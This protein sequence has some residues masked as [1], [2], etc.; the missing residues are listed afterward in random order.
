MAEIGS[1]GRG[2]TCRFI[3]S[4]LQAAA[5]ARS[6]GWDPGG[7]RATDTFRSCLVLEMLQEVAPLPHGPT[8]QCHTRADG[9][10]LIV[11]LKHMPENKTF[12]KIPLWSQR[13][14]GGNEAQ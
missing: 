5:L 7:A 12:V 6:Q 2:Q 10:S 11:I 9:H 1:G 3:G 13:E 14:Q 4:Q 8:L